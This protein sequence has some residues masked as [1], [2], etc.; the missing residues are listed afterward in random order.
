MWAVGTIALL[1]AAWRL[2][3]LCNRAI[4]MEDDIQQIKEKL[5]IKEEE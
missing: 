3:S 5:G 4:R 1:V 2:D